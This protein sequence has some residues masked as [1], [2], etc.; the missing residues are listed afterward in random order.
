[1]AK[2]SPHPRDE[3]PIPNPPVPCAPPSTKCG[4]DFSRHPIAI[5]R[6]SHQTPPTARSGIYRS[7][8]PAPACSSATESTPSNTAS[9][10]SPPQCPAPVATIETATPGPPA[11]PDKPIWT[12][13]SDLAHSS[14]SATFA[15]PRVSHTA[16]AHTLAS[17]AAIEANFMNDLPEKICYAAGTPP[18][19]SPASPGTDSHPHSAQ[20]ESH[21]VHAPVPRST[22]R[23]TPTVNHLSHVNPQNTLQSPQEPLALSHRRSPSQQEPPFPCLRSQSHSAALPVSE[24][25]ASPPPAKSYCTKIPRTPQP[26]TAT[27]AAQHDPAR[28]AA[29][30][31]A[32]I[33]T[34]RSMPPAD[35]HQ[36]PERRLHLQLF[37]RQ[38]RFIHLHNAPHFFRK[39]SNAVR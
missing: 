18:S 33:I 21:P 1:M 29:S 35:R 24:F 9:P 23:D 25:P 36:P 12:S 26:S 2:A 4:A 7:L 34:S 22:L 30:P 6:P 19:L 17:T 13:S 8:P 31:A 10:H 5:A 11:P 27:R 3:Y 38:S 32:N 39:V 20:P 15:P 37:P 14:H 28:P 16:N